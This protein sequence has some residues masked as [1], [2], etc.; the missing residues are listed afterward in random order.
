MTLRLQKDMH[1]SIYL[2]SKFWLIFLDTTCGLCNALAERMCSCFWLP[3]LEAQYST[4]AVFTSV[5]GENHGTQHKGLW[6]GINEVSLKQIL[7]ECLTQCSVMLL[8]ARSVII[9]IRSILY[10]QPRLSNLGSLDFKAWL[11]SQSA[12]L[13]FKTSLKCCGNYK[14][15]SHLNS[16]ASGTVSFLVSY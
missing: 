10:M 7:A 5:D 11:F 15:Q 4:K 9:I 2:V 3:A 12:S 6:W 13:L 8:F 14:T 16:L 1:P